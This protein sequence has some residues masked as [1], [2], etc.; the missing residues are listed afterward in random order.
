MKKYILILPIFLL[1]IFNVFVIPISAQPKALKEGF[2]K[3]EDLNLPKGVVHTVQ[4]NSSSDY[5]FIAIFDS[6]QVTRQYMR[7][8]PQSDKYI[9]VP[10]EAGYEIIIS[11]NGEVTID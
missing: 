5:A 3:A 8:Y 11:G 7:L 9:L 6:N 1:L 4:N 10:L 2:Y